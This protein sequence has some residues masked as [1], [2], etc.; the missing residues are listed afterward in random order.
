MTDRPASE[1]AEPVRVFFA[2]SAWKRVVLAEYLADHPGEIVHSRSPRRA[3]ALARARGGT[4]YC[5]GA[6]NRARLAP[7]LGPDDRLV[8]VE[9]G[10][11]RSSGLGGAYGQSPASLCFDDMGIYYDPARP[12]RLEHILANETPDQ[13]ELAAARALI[14][15][16]VA[17][18]VTKYNLTGGAEKL[19]PPAD[20]KIILVPGQVEGDQSV[21]LGGLGIAR[22]RD[23]L[24]AVR[25]SEPDAW[26]VFKPHPDVLHGYRKGHVPERL[27]RRWCD[28]I[29]RDQPISDLY[30][31]VDEVHTLTSQAGFEAL[32]RGAA[33]TVYGGPF[34]AGWGLTA[35]RHAFPRRR[36]VSLETLVRGTLM[37]Y[38]RYLH[39]LTRR[40]VAALELAQ[41]FAEGLRTPRV[42]APVHA[43]LYHRLM[44]PSRRLAR[45][46]F[47]GA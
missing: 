30:D 25:Q 2:L 47:A 14:E 33:V 12:S 9:D 22:N 45:R 8:V 41:G 35:D 16:L 42:P 3:V 21:L 5:W 6:G 11:V 26:I 36:P 10:F 24:R 23:L 18:R 17:G 37:R 13:A 15:L 39:P 20:R 28:A 1:P 31:V 38:P 44:P 40:P 27:A 29:A 34:Y 32:L 43:R 4:V 7:W 46:L 19:R